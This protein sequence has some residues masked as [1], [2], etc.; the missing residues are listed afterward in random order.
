MSLSLAPLFYGSTFK[1]NGFGI[2]VGF[3]F[4]EKYRDYGE[5]FF[6]PNSFYAS[7]DLF[8]DTQ[9]IKPTLDPG[10]PLDNGEINYAGGIFGIGALWKIR[11]A[12]SQRLI[13]NFG[14]SLEFFAANYQLKYDGEKISEDTLGFDP[15]IGLHGGLSFRFTRLISLDFGLAWKIGFIG[16]N[17]Q[18]GIYDGGG[19]WLSDESFAKGVHPYTFTG[20]LG[21]SFWLPR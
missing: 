11:L 9:T 5:F 10:F 20:S 3:T 12:E 21:L 13:T 1:G 16:K 18:I 6:L 15:G 17:P 19:N 2:G 4:Y 7:V 14:L 8:S